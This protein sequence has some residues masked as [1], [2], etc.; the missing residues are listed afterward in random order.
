M[1]RSELKKLIDVAKGVL[2][3]DIV[4][5]GAE[6]VDVC[7]GT[8]SEGDIAIVDGLIAG[9]G[10]YDGREVVDANGYYAAPGMI[11]GHIHIESAYVSPEELGRMAV[12]RGTTTIIADP[13]EIVNVSGLTGLDYMLEASENTKLDIRYMV[14]SCVPATPFEDSGAVVK[15]SD[16]RSYMGD[17]RVG[18]LGE[19]MDFVG[20]INGDETALDK[21]VLCHEYDKIID[22]HS[23][24]LFGNDLNAYAAAGILND[25]ECSTV[26]EMQDR[27][28]RGMYVIMRYGT[29]AYDLKTLLKGLTTENSRRCILCSDDRQAK[30]FIEEG[31]LNGHLRLCVEA[32]MDPVSAIRLGTLNAAECFRL[33]DRGMLTPGRRADIVLYR[34]LEAFEAA[35]V[36]IK[37]ELI[38]EN[39]EYLPSFTKTPIDRVKGSVHIDAFDQSQLNLPLKTDQAHVIEIKADDI[40][41]GNKIMRVARA[42]DGSFVFDPS[43]DAAKIAV[44][45]RHHNTGKAAVGLISGYGIKRGAIAQSIAHD[46]HNIMTVG[47]ND[48]DM[49]LAVKTLAEIGGGIVITCEGA[50]VQTMAL[51][52]AGIMS[53]KSGEEVREELTAIHKAAREV[54]GVG[55]DLDPVMHL[56]FMS[57][58]VIPE[59]RITD[60]GLFDVSA[61]DFI[62][63][64]A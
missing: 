26:K 37:G 51:P 59:L 9:I 20:V 28:A 54:L 50:V 44:I 8:I 38:A 45:E 64:D 25:H 18:G 60:R 34:D 58:N 19:F 35:K 29:A 5:K 21:I 63:V 46:A 23:P 27:I 6:I 1:T 15:A 31:H 30:S 49:T 3:A 55:E 33:Y 42:E 7:S 2:P 11:D 16:M 62:S 17:G 47:T 41:T 24:G 22:G 10:S 12:P 32:G 36:Y 13:H 4:I 14:P 48:E 56:G 43:I 39:G 57:L 61:F 53:D 40:I 52:I